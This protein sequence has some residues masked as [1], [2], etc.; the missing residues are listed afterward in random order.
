MKITFKISSSKKGKVRQRYSQESDDFGFGSCLMPINK[1]Q[2]R[3]KIQ[4]CSVQGIKFV[5]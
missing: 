2:Q 5:V 3:I 4:P 1:K